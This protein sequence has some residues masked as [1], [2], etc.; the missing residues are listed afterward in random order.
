MFYQIFS[1]FFIKIIRYYATSAQWQTHSQCLINQNDFMIKSSSRSWITL[2]LIT[3]ESQIISFIIKVILKNHFSSFFRKTS[4]TIPSF[5]D[6]CPKE[7]HCIIRNMFTHHVPSSK[8]SLIN[9]F[10]IMRNSSYI[11][12][13]GKSSIISCS[14]NIIV[15]QQILICIHEEW[16]VSRIYTGFICEI[17]S[18]WLISNSIKNQICF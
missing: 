7:R 16:I 6:I 8:S 12:S 15:I 18:V 2:C 11:I 5:K 17:R 3:I 1:Q 13:Q 4:V 9:S 14:K 10:S